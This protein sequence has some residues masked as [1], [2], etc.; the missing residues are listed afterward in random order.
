MRYR[1]MAVGALVL[2]ALGGCGAR[3][4]GRDATAGTDST[5]TA[6]LAASDVQR[7]GRADLSAGIPVSGTLEPAVD[8]TI[9]APLGEVLDEVMVKEGQAVAK[10]EPIARF[11]DT[12]LRPAAE[13][14]EARAKIAA[15]DYERM[16]NLFREGAVSERD[17]EN[18]EAELRAS[19]AA[20]ADA[21]TQLDDATVRAPVAGVIAKR[22]VQGGDRLGVGDPMFR[23]VN[24]SSLEFEATVPSEYAGRV[25][26]GA[27]VR[28]TVSGM[29]HDLI[30]GRVARI[31]ATADP[32]TRQV[33]LYV[34]VPNRRGR[35]VGD[36]YAT[37]RIVLARADSVVAI[38]SA[39]V[40]ADQDGTQWVW[41][42]I[43][44]H[45]ERRVVKTGV[46]DEARDLV[47]VVSGLQPGDTA[48]VNAVPGLANGL[49]V[50][51]AGREG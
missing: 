40:H 35:L 49:R 44:G 15:S 4:G 43:G 22:L 6:F 11:R 37:G 48:V 9:S 46:R 51:I 27:P 28:L 30:P 36:L 47:G 14:A 2:A 16:Q 23:L 38:P 13:S 18:A 39:G 5:R 31:N 50:T 20:L 19:Q 41:L 33:R 32:A 17:V 29:E 8:V 1:V 45:L 34:S 12:A 25:R 24:V 42:V 7:L 3:E 10:G 21:R 26:V